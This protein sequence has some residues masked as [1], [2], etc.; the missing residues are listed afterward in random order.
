M[1]APRAARLWPRTASSSARRGARPWTRIVAIFAVMSA[2]VHMHAGATTLGDMLSGPLDP[3]TDENVEEATTAL[4]EVLS[5]LKS[6][7]EAMPKPEEITYPWDTIKL[8]FAECHGGPAYAR[9]APAN[10]H[11][12][13]NAEKCGLCQIIVENSMMWNWK[14]HL[15]ALCARVPRHM[16]PMCR[17]FACLMAIECPEFI[18]S[19]CFEDGVE[20]FPCPPKYVC[21]NCLKLPEKQYAG[22]F[23]DRN[24]P[25]WLTN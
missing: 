13:T 8:T 2:S 12:L 23:D 4:V 10:V 3:T 19:K 1:V 11:S 16:L 24:I 21:W 9:G 20:R 17:H 6:G 5:T 7:A 14:R 15:S 18:T 22:C 25:Y